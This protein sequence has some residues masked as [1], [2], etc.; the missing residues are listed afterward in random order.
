MKKSKRQNKRFP[1]KNKEALQNYETT[2]G[3]PDHCGRNEKPEAHL[4]RE[5]FLQGT[6]D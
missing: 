1:A 6:L 4:H 2:E 3:K 5:L